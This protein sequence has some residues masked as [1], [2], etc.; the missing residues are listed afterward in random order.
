MLRYFV[1]CREDKLENACFKELP[2]TDIYIFFVI[3]CKIVLKTVLRQNTDNFNVLGGYKYNSII[4]N[5]VVTFQTY[6]IRGVHFE[7]DYM[8]LEMKRTYKMIS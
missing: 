1:I 6:T 7:L 2:L 5:E 8:V 3:L 4:I